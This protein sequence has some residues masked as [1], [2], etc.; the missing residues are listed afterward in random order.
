MKKRNGPARLAKHMADAVYDEVIPGAASELGLDLDDPAV[1]TA[2]LI[3]VGSHSP[4]EP[5]AP[6][7]AHI[8]DHIDEL[9]RKSFD[10]L[11]RDNVPT[12]ETARW[13]A[14]NTDLGGRL[15]AMVAAGA[16]DRA[17]HEFIAAVRQR[18]PWAAYVR[19]RD[20]LE[21]ELASRYRL[22]PCEVEH[23]WHAVPGGLAIH[24]RVRPYAWAT[25]GV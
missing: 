25:G 10:D 15:W 8:R 6:Q 18:W 7:L 17:V 4:R 21:R 23:D 22:G 14:E 20:A 19:D 24:C 9:S 3:T 1:A 11:L 13:E 2:V 5:L 16:D 12:P